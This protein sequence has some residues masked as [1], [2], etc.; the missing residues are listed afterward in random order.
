MGGN[1]EFIINK[2]RAI[3]PVLELVIGLPLES[4]AHKA[5]MHHLRLADFDFQLKENQEY[6]WFVF[7]VPDPEQRS[8]D[9]IAS[10]TIR[11]ME[12]PADLIPRLNQ[13]PAEQ[14]YQVYAEAGLWYDAIDHLCQQVD[15][16][17]ENKELRQIRANLTTQVAMP[18]VADYDRAS[19]TAH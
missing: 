16:N 12:P 14:W 15:Q 1:L 10:G 11:Y 19:L 18:K 7:I 17:P 3:E 13:T 5:G 8:A 4:D 6:E 9:L 2:V